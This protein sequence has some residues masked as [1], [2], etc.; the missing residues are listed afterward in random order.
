MA[1]ILRMT[2]ALCIITG[3]ILFLVRDQSP[4]SSPLLITGCVLVLVGRLV[5]RIQRARR[6]S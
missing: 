2:G 5:Y 3:G 1:A 4:L 6:S